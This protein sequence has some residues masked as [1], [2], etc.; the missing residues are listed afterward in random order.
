MGDTIKHR[1]R[2]PSTAHTSASAS[3]EAE[4][5]AEQAVNLSLPWCAYPEIA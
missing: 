1:E 4:Q 3:E 2:L 5:E